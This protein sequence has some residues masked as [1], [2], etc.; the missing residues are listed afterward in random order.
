MSKGAWRCSCVLGG[1]GVNHKGGVGLPVGNSGFTHLVV[2]FL[3]VEACL[4]AMCSAGR[5]CMW[6]RGG[7]GGGG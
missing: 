6:G 2:I 4:R 7:S 3:L 5:V 1:G